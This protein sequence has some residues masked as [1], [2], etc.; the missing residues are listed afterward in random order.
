MRWRQTCTLDTWM[1]IWAPPRAYSSYRAWLIRQLGGW[2]CQSGS[3]RSEAAAR[4]TSWPSRSHFILPSSGGKQLLS[5]QDDSSWTPGDPFP[6]LVPTTNDPPSE[7]MVL[8]FDS[9]SRW[10][11]EFNVGTVRLEVHASGV[12]YIC[13]TIIA[14]TVENESGE[15]EKREDV[16]IDA[17]CGYASV[18]SAGRRLSAHTALAPPQLLSS[19]AARRGLDV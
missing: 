11:E 9:T 3:T 19:A 14:L 1:S 7:F 5:V 15:A 6:N 8:A 2:T 12:H 4:D 10:S 13:G 16:P 18:V 17:G